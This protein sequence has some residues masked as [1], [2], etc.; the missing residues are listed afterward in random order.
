MSSQNQQKKLGDTCKGC[1]WLV[2]GDKQKDGT[3]S[4]GCRFY[5]TSLGFH[6]SYPPRLSHCDIDGRITNELYQRKRRL[7]T[8]PTEESNEDQV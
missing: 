1:A 3:T 2:T 7:N 4:Y 8:E 6:K 5:H